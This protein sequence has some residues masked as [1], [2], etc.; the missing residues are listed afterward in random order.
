VWALRIGQSLVAL[1]AC[2]TVLA[3]LAVGIWFTGPWVVEVLDDDCSFDSSKWK[4]G[5]SERDLQ[6]KF[7]TRAEEAEELV[8][9]GTLDNATES[10]VTRL[11]GRPGSTTPDYWFYDIGVPEPRSDYPQLEV[12]FDAATGRV[13]QV[14][15]PGH[16]DGD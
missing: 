1:A 10:E 11:L 15:V 4:Q 3:L 16:A 6:A 13:D 5:R 7:D 8:D 12:R 2:I 9:C 14:L